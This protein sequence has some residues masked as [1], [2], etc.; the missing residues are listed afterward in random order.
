MAFNTPP[1][2]PPAPQSAVAAPSPPTPGKMTLAQFSAMGTTA[3]APVAQ[4]SKGPPG[5]SG[6]PGSGPPPLQPGQQPQPQAINAPPAG[7]P[8]PSRPVVGPH[9]GSRS[10]G[11]HASRSPNKQANPVHGLSS[12]VKAVLGG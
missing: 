11:T 10:V 7:G 6:Q 1:N 4:V 5:G 8:K 12:L 2:V 9:G 3:G